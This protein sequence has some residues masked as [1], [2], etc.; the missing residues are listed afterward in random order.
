MATNK[1][2]PQDIID[3]AIEVLEDADD[4]E[5][6]RSDLAAALTQALSI[7]RGQEEEADTDD[8]DDDE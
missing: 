4:V 2:D 6:T 7:L 5:S 3:R 8:G 1:A